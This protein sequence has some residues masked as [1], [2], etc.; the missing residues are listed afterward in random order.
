M[1]L[2]DH[3]V[4]VILPQVPH[5]IALLHKRLVALRTREGL[6]AA[7]RSPVRDQVALADKVL[8]TE[9]AAEGAVRGGA[10]VMAAHME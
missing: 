10:L 5:Q 4:A 8:G 7:V 3:R 1:R 2:N 6:F 9:V